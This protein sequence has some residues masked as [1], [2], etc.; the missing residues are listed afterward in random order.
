[1]YSFISSG[2]ICPEPEAEMMV[3]RTSGFSFE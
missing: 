2:C 1:M 3:F